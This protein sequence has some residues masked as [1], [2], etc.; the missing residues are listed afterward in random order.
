MSD[1]INRTKSIQMCL[2]G[3]LWIGIRLLLC[4]RSEPLVP[5]ELY[6]SF[7]LKLIYFFWPRPRTKSSTVASSHERSFW[8]KHTHE[9]LKPCFTQLRPWR[10]VTG[11]LSPGERTLEFLFIFIKF[12]P[13]THTFCTKL[14]LNPPPILSE[15]FTHPPAPLRKVNS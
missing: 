4:S 2:F 13:P 1:S 9:P 3:G 12:Y 6:R 14:I 10:P 7:L 15:N 11:P 5:C 8:I